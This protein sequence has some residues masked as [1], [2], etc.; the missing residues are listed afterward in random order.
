MPVSDDILEKIRSSGFEIANAKE[1]SL[2]AEQ[3]AEF[4]KEHAEQDYFDKLVKHM[5]RSVCRFM[6]SSRNEKV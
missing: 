5:S 6:W 2:T 1:V 4:Y 3:A